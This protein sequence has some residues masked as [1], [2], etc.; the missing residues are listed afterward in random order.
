MSEV[1][2]KVNEDGYNG[3]SKSERI[4]NHTEQNYDL[5][6][7]K[8]EVALA[9]KKGIANPVALPI[10][11]KAMAKAMKYA[12]YQHKDMLR[13]DDI[14]EAQDSL[15]AIAE[16]KGE[17]MTVWQR[18]AP[19]D[20]GV[21]IDLGGEASNR[22][23]VTKD[24]V[25]THVTNS[26]TLFSHSA[27]SSELPSVAEEGDWTKIFPYLNMVKEHMLILVAYLTYILAHPKQADVGYPIL[28]IKG[29]QGSGKS[30]L[31]KSLIRALVDPNNYGIQMFPSSIKEMAIS[32]KN[33]FVLIYDNI[34]KL[35]HKWS[36]ALCISSTGGSLSGRK[37]FA[38][39]EEVNFDLHG[40]KIL[41]GIHNFLTE[42]DA[43]SR[44]ANI[45]LLPMVANRRKNEKELIQQLELDMPIIFRGLLDLISKCFA[46]EGTET[47]THP[48]RMMGFVHWLAKIELAEGMEV[49]TLQRI[50]A[51][52]QKEA[53]LDTI[54]EDR[55]AYAVLT[56]AKEYTQNMWS[57]TPTALLEELSSRVPTKVSKYTQNWPQTAISLSKRL[58]VLKASL[59]AQGVELILGE[60]AKERRIL[61]GM[62]DSYVTDVEPNE[63]TEA[64][65][66]LNI[67]CDIDEAD[68]ALEPNK[69]KKRLRFN[70]SK[71][72]SQDA[73]NF[74]LSEPAKDLSLPPEPEEQRTKRL[75]A[76]V[77]QKSR[78]RQ[79]EEGYVRPKRPVRRST[80]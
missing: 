25:N 59:S 32:V 52:N 26:Q 74:D 39:D 20:G 55:L 6:T 31:C 78:D 10:N 21:E 50:Y 77:A 28:V 37:L 27:T 33:A 9:I 8:N 56:M 65:G 29:E 60:R 69:L 12:G 23:I 11:G 24:G 53:M 35:D 58:G 68:E 18:N 2:N 42:S 47:I 16:F 41:N 71:K 75:R 5:G 40:P 63:P 54:A 19:L 36:D 46:V 38:D 67:N 76:I 43:V 66:N 57:G 72:V 62:Q 7:D 17:D 70:R 79:A 80:L 3:G 73:P 13:K 14:K 22:V 15:S 44:C 34:R 45:Q 1:E 49:G 61:L 51:E 30:F 64:S 4:V 48:Q